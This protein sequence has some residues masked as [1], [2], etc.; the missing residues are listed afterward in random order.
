MKMIGSQFPSVKIVFKIRVLWLYRFLTKLHSEFV[1]FKQKSMQYPKL[2]AKITFF[3]LFENNSSEWKSLNNAIDPMNCFDVLNYC[4]PLFSNCTHSAVCCALP[5][6][7]QLLGPLFF[8]F[9]G[10]TQSLLTTRQGKTP[11]LTLHRKQ[12]LMIFC[13]F[14]CKELYLYSVI[15]NWIW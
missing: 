12:F 8:A 6:D 1:I 13:D 7:M 3:M 5:L 2:K 10:Q 4:T 9:S 14:F 15:W 11:P